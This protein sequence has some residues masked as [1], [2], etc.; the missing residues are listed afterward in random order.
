[1]LASPLW[2][3]SEATCK[4]LTAVKLCPSALLPYQHTTLV[5]K[6]SNRLNVVLCSQ[7]HRYSSRIASLPTGIQPNESFY[8]NKHM[9]LAH[10]P[11]ACSAVSHTCKRCQGVMLLALQLLTTVQLCKMPCC[12]TSILSLPGSSCSMLCNQMHTR[13]GSSTSCSRLTMSQSTRHSHSF[14]NPLSMH[15]CNC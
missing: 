3:S 6:L 7:Q 14:C 4:L 13:P 1:M 2:H 5:G 15:T 10:S 11:F 8:P 12:V 9:L